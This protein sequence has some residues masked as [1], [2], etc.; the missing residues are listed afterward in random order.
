[1]KGHRL[2][3][4]KK[5]KKNKRKTRR[6]RRKRR[7]MVNRKKKS[8]ERGDEVKVGGKR[9]RS[10]QRQPRVINFPGSKTSILPLFFPP[11]SSYP[12]LTLRCHW[13]LASPTDGVLPSCLPQPPFY[14]G[15]Q[16]PRKLFTLAVERSSSLQIFRRV[17]LLLA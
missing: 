2:D 3:E 17:R 6:R 10:T 16:P 12:L 1:M 14:V 5:R 15:A 8:I 13:P 7:R 4:I 11:P 9:R